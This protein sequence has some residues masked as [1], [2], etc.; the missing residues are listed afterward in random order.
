MLGMKGVNLIFLSLLFL[1]SCSIHADDLPFYSNLE[2]VF[3]EHEGSIQDFSEI[4]E[5]ENKNI[6][7][8]YLEGSLLYKNKPD[9]RWQPY[10][11]LDLESYSKV[12]KVVKVRFAGRIEEKIYLGGMSQQVEGKMVIIDM[13][14]YLGPVPHSDCASSFLS[15]KNGS[16]V[17]HIKNG[18]MAQYSW[19]TY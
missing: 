11:G 15:G 6:K 16:C 2:E 13:V 12:M 4:L 17:A 10:T 14:K 8:Q 19:V 1:S 5:K 9:D 3:L 7:L 18:W